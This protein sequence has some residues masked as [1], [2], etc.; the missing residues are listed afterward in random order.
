MI[1]N[2]ILLVLAALEMFFLVWNIKEK[3]T[4]LRWKGIARLGLAAV[5][6]VLMI[7]GVLEG[8]SRYAGIILALT[9]LGLLSLGKF[10]NYYIFYIFLK[11][12]HNL[13]IY[14]ILIKT[15]IL[16]QILLIMLL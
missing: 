5:L 4:H 7:V 6:T 12:H 1:T 3:R 14:L 10:L 2:I 9:V 15:K 8:L 11:L 16:F 13:N